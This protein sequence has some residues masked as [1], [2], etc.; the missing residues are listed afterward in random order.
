MDVKQFFSENKGSIIFSLVFMIAI[1]GVYFVLGATSFPISEKKTLGF[2]EDARYKVAFG[3]DGTPTVFVNAKNNELSA[4]SVSEGNPIPEEDSIVIGADQ[5]LQL[6]QENL[7]YRTG[8]HLVNYFEI[9]TTIGGVLEKRNDLLDDLTFVSSN[10]F[11]KISGTEDKLFLKMTS[12]NEPKLFFKLEKPELE[13][14]SLVFLDGASNN[15]LTHDIAGRTYYPLVLG[16]KEAKKMQDEKLFRN[17][18]DELTGFFDQNFIVV[19]ILSETNTSLDR[20]YL[21]S[22]GG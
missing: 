7:F 17:T 20:M 6:K 15:Y 4:L 1:S 18:G 14:R 21:T 16:Y 22:F 10:Q 5:Q 12:K 19:G 3:V 11:E 13:A 2:L 9:N 8:N